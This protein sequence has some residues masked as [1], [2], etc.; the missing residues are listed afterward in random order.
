MNAASS[1]VVAL[2]STELTIAV[3]ST[4][5]VTSS[6]P[7]AASHGTRETSVPRQIRAA[8]ASTSA[9]WAKSR[10]RSGPPKSAKSSIAIEPKAANTA[11]PGLPRT[12]SASENRTGITIAARVLR[13]SA[14]RPASRRRIQCR[15]VVTVPPLDW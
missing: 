9:P 8:V 7:T 1:A 3:N 15:K 4:T 5:K 10:S 14:E 11:T 13:R 2:A 6:T 12:T